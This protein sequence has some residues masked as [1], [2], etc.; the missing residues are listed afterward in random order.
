MNS[1]EYFQE[2]TIID[3]TF[4]ENNETTFEWLNRST[5]DRAAEIRRFLNENLNQLP[6]NVSLKIFKGL[7]HQWINSLFELIVAR[8]L[9]ILGGKLS[10]EQPNKDGRKPD[11]KARFDDYTLIV[12]A[13]AP[14]FDISLSEEE[15][16]D[17]QVIR[18]IEER[19]PSDWCVLLDTIPK[20]GP[21]ESKSNL[22]LAIEELF[23]NLPDNDDNYPYEVQKRLPQGFLTL[24]IFPGQEYEKSIIG[25]PTY[26]T[27]CDTKQRIKRAIKKKRS[28]VRGSKNPVIL[29]VLASGISSDF[30]D[31]NQVVFGLE[32]A[33]LGFDRKPYKVEFNANGEF[34]KGQGTP[35]YAGLMAFTKLTPFG[36]RGPILYIHPRFGGN[37]PSQFDKIEQRILT[38]DGIKI[39]EPNSH[40]VHNE[41][42]WA[43]FI[44]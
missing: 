34:A 27:W 41:L 8:Y 37:L 28:Q 15:K 25:G 10:Y 2:P 39:K 31:F 17:A 14:E 26:S 44:K 5:L 7:E 13:T 6:K 35:T 40:D 22:K 9:Q 3:N 18:I 36:C 21:S 4:A 38:I 29:A 1:I 12:E 23:S 32:T 20:Y 19:I 42:S 16:Y 43:T 11:F 24:T 30:I 33:Y